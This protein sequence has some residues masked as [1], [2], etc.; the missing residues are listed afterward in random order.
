MILTEE[1]R[2]LKKVIWDNLNKDWIKEQKQKRKDNKEKRKNDKLKRKRRKSLGKSFSHKLYFVGDIIKTE[3]KDPA[4]AIL[5]SSKMVNI[6]P[7]GKVQ[8]HV[9]NSL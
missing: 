3:A 1:E 9:Y 6:N 4:E 7:R 5:S 2:N 8:D